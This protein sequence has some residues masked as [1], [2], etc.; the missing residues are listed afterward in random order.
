VTLSSS[1]PVPVNVITG[2]LG[3]GKTTAIAKLLASKPVDEYWVVILNEFTDVG[4]DALTLAAAARG[5]YDVRAIPGGCLC[6]TGELDFRRQLRAILQE[7]RPHRILIEPSGIGHPGAVIEELR[8]QERVGV[9]RLT[10]TVGLVDPKRLGV[11]DSESVERDQLTAADVL[12]LSKADTATADEQRLFDAKARAMFPPKRWIGLSEAGVLATTALSPPIAAYEFMLPVRPEL[13]SHA[14]AHSHQMHVQERTV[15]FG[16]HSAGATEHSLLNRQA[17]GWTIPREVTFNRV[18]LMESLQHNT[19][20]LLSNVE[21]LKAVL[22][23]GI[24][25][26][27]LINVSPA[28]VSD[29]PCG[30]RQDS[31]IEVQGREGE[32]IEWAQWDKFW[33]SMVCR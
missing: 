28:G 29:E 3:V 19:A 17:C 20:E 11:F 33:N 1:T 5:A 6:C 10:S 30:W 22:R 32:H 27:A 7:R 31:R 25:H 13:H 8:G 15:L 18:K 14:Q 4:V 24:D 12:L 16:K 21:R 23:T 26:W 2:A 9:L